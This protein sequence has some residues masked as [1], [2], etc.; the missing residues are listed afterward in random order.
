MGNRNRA[1]AVSAVR[2]R[3]VLFS[4]GLVVL[5]SGCGQSADSSA[6]AAA[7]PGEETYNRFCFSCHQAGVAG[8]PRFGDA[9]AWAPR[10]AQGRDVLLAHTK[11]GVPPGMPAM[12]LCT[13]CTEQNL[14]DA[15]D[16]M[17]SAAS[18]DGPTGAP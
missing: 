9:Q 7:H 4:L 5:V 16:Y 12:G 3:R 2:I 15:I 10:I 8:A 18:D 1:G 14:V 11:A 17:V 6:K 13:S